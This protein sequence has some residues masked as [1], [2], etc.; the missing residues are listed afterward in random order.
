MRIFINQYSLSL[1]AN[2]YAGLCLM[3]HG[4]YTLRFVPTAS[5]FN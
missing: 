3:N 1:Q 2:I 5:G 4:Y